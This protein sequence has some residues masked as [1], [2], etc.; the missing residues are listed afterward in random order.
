MVTGTMGSL[1]IKASIIGASSYQSAESEN[2]WGEKGILYQPDPRHVDVL[3]ESLGLENGNTVQTPI[4]DDVKGE[5]PVWLDS[6][7]I[8]KD[9]SHVARCLFLSQDGADIT[10]AVNELCQRMSDPS[11]HRFS[12]LM[13]L[14]RYLKEE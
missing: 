5:N 14:V 2:T 9:R 7:Q 10:F 6:E 4:I 12:K 11:R 1:L 3:V 8:S 13:R